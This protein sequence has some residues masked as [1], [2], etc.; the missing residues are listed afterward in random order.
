MSTGCNKVHFA[1]YKKITINTVEYI[2]SSEF[3]LIIA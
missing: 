2:Y 1:R 3:K